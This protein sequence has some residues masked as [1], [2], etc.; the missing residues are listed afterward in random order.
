MEDNEDLDVQ[1]QDFSDINRLRAV[2]NTPAI[3]DPTL[4]RDLPPEDNSLTLI[5]PLDTVTIDRLPTQIESY[6]NK[7]YPASSMKEKF[8]DYP[9][10]I[11]PKKLD[12]GI[13]KPTGWAK[14]VELN[15]EQIQKKLSYSFGPLIALTKQIQHLKETSTLPEITE[16]LA[17]IEANEWLS[18]SFLAISQSMISLQYL[19]RINI[20]KDW[21]GQ[22]NPQL[23]REACKTAVAINDTYEENLF[24]RAFNKNLEELKKLPRPTPS[25]TFNK[26]GGSSG[27][28]NYKKSS[29]PVRYVD[30]CNKSSDID[31]KIHRNKF[32]SDLTMPPRKKIRFLNSGR[33]Q[34]ST[35][36][37]RSHDS[38]KANPDLAESQDVTDSV[39][40]AQDVTE[41][42]RPGTQDVIHTGQSHKNLSQIVQSTKCTPKMGNAAQ[43]PVQQFFP[44]VARNGP[45]FGQLATVNEGPSSSNMGIGS[46]TRPQRESSLSSR[47]DTIS[48][49][50]GPREA[51]GSK[52]T[53]TNQSRN[54]SSMSRSKIPGGSI[55]QTKTRGQIPSNNR[56]ITSEQIRKLR[57]LQDGQ[58]PN[59][60]RSNESRRLDV[61]NGSPERLLLC[62]G[63]PGTPTVPGICLEKPDMDVHASMFWPL[64]MPQDI[65]KNSETGNN[66]SQTTGSQVSFFPRRL[67][68]SPQVEGS[69]RAAHPNPNGETTQSRLCREHE[70]EHH[71]TGKIPKILG[72]EYLLSNHD[73]VPTRG[74][75]RENLGINP[76]SADQS[77]DLSTEYGTS[78]GQTGSHKAGIQHDSSILSKPAK[79]DDTLSDRG[80]LLV[81]QDKASGT[82][83]V[84]RTVFLATHVTAAKTSKSKSL[85][86]G[87]SKVQNR[88][89]PVRVGRLGR[90]TRNVRKVVQ[91]RTRAPYKS[92]RATQYI[93]GA[94]S[95]RPPTEKPDCSD[96]RGQHNEPGIYL[97]ERGCP[98]PGTLRQSHKGLGTSSKVQHK[99][100]DR[101]RPR[102]SE[103]GCRLS[104]ESLPAQLQQ[105]HLD[106]DNRVATEPLTLPQNI[107][108]PR[109]ITRSQTRH[110]CESLEPSAQPL[111]HME[112]ETCVDERVPL[113]VAGRRLPVP[114]VHPD[115]QSIEEDPGRSL[116]G[117][118]RD[119]QMGESELVPSPNQHDL[120]GQ[121]ANAP[122]TTRSSTGPERKPTSNE[123]PKI[124]GMANHREDLLKRGFSNLAA[125]LMIQRLSENSRKNYN[126]TWNLWIQYAE[127]RGEDPYMD[128]ISI[129]L[130]AD[131]FTHEFRT[132]KKKSSSISAHKGA[133]MSCFSDRNARK[134]R[135]S[136]ELTAL[137]TSIRRADPPRAR[138]QEIWDPTA[139]IQAWDVPNDTLSLYHLS[140]KTFTLLAL[141][142]FARMADLRALSATIDP[143]NFLRD[144]NGVV[145]RILLTSIS[146]PKQLQQS[147]KPLKPVPV[148]CE[149]DNINI[150]PVRTLLYYLE[151]TKHLRSA[152]TLALFVT[153]TKPY[154]AIA[155]GTAA[156]WLLFSMDKGGIDTS[157]YKAHSTCSAG[158]SQA[159]KRGLTYNQLMSKRRWSSLKT[160]VNVYIKHHLT[161]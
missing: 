101:I 102:N 64:A 71:P 24:G 121:K 46:N 3:R 109:W 10:Y 30:D 11:T 136:R 50:P 26:R 118:N 45:I 125:D 154:K 103:L 74:Q 69:V 17:E 63:R 90:R 131:F 111:H 133:L 157:Q 13:P 25:H 135:D 67:L 91:H 15:V 119:S 95:I 22:S 148:H 89:V 73:S 35:T 79:V 92:V 14:E 78:H 21:W 152:D 7:F 48:S 100:R 60:L 42:S 68:D 83:T 75:K 18:D 51:P 56:S 137:I 114:P 2:V 122:T 128:D 153:S 110:L 16:K 139:V 43:L 87:S 138:Y 97:Q 72:N 123:V 80:R 149:T 81:T 96:M 117:G 146:L 33:G 29:K 57:T 8:E 120:P 104:V 86:R 84:R 4:L 62:V 61:P 156:R 38:L 77:T 93:Q 34:S 5:K 159:V 36:V 66:S 160:P 65:H 130:V 49:R 147:S 106:G 55:P 129:P 99:S 144:N 127:S 132:K 151:T 140:I 143:A 108:E 134:V 31:R 158:V 23:A 9:S 113:Q 88:C 94:K 32:H 37:S 1:G 12:P 41:I 44:A 82:R 155:A 150:C 54:C 76:Q 142:T 107:Q 126:S 105:L 70:K 145:T 6:L 53:R 141:H 52:D 39:A 161:K 112:R 116:R 58:P 98:E 28:S 40:T 124:S 115:Q 85:R 27:Y 19:R 20:L 47:S 59:I